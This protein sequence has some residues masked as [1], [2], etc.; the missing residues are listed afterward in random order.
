MWEAKGD[1]DGLIAWWRADV[2]PGLPEGVGFELFQ[3]AD[4]VV[5]LVRPAEAGFRVPE[6]P[7]ELIARPPHAWPF[8]TVAE[9][10]SVSP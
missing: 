3:S 2:A 6:P 4:R 9:S 1:A 7:G 10:G 5:A 8:E